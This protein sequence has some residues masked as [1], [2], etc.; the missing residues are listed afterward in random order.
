[1]SEKPQLPRSTRIIYFVFDFFFL[2]KKTIL[3]VLAVAI[4]LGIAA[5]GLRVIKKEEQ[6]VLTRFGKVVNAEVGPGIRYRIPLIEKLYV[7]KVKRVVTH[8]VSSI[9]NGTA[10]FTILSGDMNLVEV[11]FS[12][13]YKIKDLRS[14]L[15]RNSDPLMT[16]TMLVR[17][18]L[19]EVFSR[20]FIDLIFTSN[21][22]HIRETVLNGLIK[23]LEAIDSGIEVVSLNI[24]DV[25]PVQEAVY[26]FRDINDA[27]AERQ[28][29]IS[30]ANLKK[31]H[32]LAHT[33]GQA[34]ALIENAKAI[35]HER[36]VSA[37]SSAGVFRALL[38]E[39][40]KNP[41]HVA[42]TRYWKR[43]N[44]I[45]ADASLSALPLG[46]DATIDI[47]MIEDSQGFL[48]MPVEIP[49]DLPPG[50]VS[51]SDRRLFASTAVPTFHSLETTEAD[52]ATMSG[53]FHKVR[54]ERDHISSATPRSLIFYIPSFSHSH[55][56]QQIP[57]VA[58]GTVQKQALNVSGDKGDS[59]K[60]ESKKDQDGK[61][62]Q[63]EKE[64]SDKERKTEGKKE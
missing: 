12:V 56:E 7:R 38:S 14:Y 55:L 31:E 57:S 1:M 13:Q 49:A 48:P 51:A 22:D 30:N 3:P 53:Q 28:K 59:S 52:K 27:I 11:D 19:V 32:L 61:V 34:D 39:Y 43:M 60:K 62:G 36:I 63:S 17:K 44:T 23:G 35:A 37:K 6:G 4:V 42:V 54:T 26:A 8:Q 15:F 46:K 50:S 16:M 41:K 64:N 33:K 2:R 24:V 9:E 29:A 58:G 21:R 47:N 10:N 40:R 45:F 18:E 25:R 5:T 20:N